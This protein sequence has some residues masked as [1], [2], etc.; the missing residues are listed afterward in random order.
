MDSNPSILK[1]NDSL[2]QVVHTVSE[3]NSLFYPVVDG[4]FRLIGI[5]SFLKIKSLFII[6]GLEDLVLACDLMTDVRAVTVPE[7]RL[8]DA[9]KDAL[10]QGLR[11]T[12]SN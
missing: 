8:T 5:V 4:D 1:S 7:A 6:E 10:V 12:L 2:E 3:S 11:T 9:E